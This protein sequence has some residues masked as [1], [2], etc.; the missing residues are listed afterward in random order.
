[1]ASARKKT[2]IA[3]DLAIFMLENGGLMTWLEYRALGGGPYRLATI[4]RVFGN[5][6][7]ALRYLEQSQP[8]LW[9]ELTESPQPEEI[10]APMIDLSAIA[11]DENE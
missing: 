4:K 1:M 7:R 6:N 3:G 5:W 10:P 8:D 2:I 11:N 9:L